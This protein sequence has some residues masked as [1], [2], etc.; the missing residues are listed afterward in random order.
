MESKYSRLFPVLMIVAGSTAGCFM[1]QPIVRLTPRAPN[2]VWI[3][4][5]ASVQKEDTGVRTAVAFEHQNGSMLG[6]RVEVQNLTAT[7]IDI[8]PQDFSYVT[9][10]GDA[11]GS[12][13]AAK[14]LVD[15]ES[16]LASLD[17][18]ESRE[19][20]GAASDAAFM[21]PLLLLSVVADVGS[22]A[23][24]H[25]GRTT[26]LQTAAVSNQMENDTVRH[27]VASA[28]IGAQRELWSNAAL[29]RNTVPPGGGVSGFV[30]IP[31]EP[32]VRNL[33]LTVRAGGR[34]FPFCFRQDVTEIDPPT[35]TTSSYTTQH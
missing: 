3:A 13:G 15:P 5:R 10:S 21:G 27:E 7:A 19:E 20:A 2:V 11:V 26:G 33:W 1:P 22:I 35:T 25:A 12:C 16:V 30:Y 28:S 24:G 6:V 34:R 4:G 23:S 8:K 29:R 17:V 18:N 14:P 31:I 32:K 9:C